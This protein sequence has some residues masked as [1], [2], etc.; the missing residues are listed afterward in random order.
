MPILL[1]GTLLH[2]QPCSDRRQLPRFRFKADESFQ[3]G[4]AEQTPVASY[5]D[6][7]GE[8]MLPNSSMA[9]CLLCALCGHEPGLLQRVRCFATTWAA[10][11]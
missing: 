5:L 6:V 8:R 2:L 10:P 3:I 9:S 1:C 11:A 7:E 4:T